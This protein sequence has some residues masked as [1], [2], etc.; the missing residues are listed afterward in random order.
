MVTLTV[1][2]PALASNGVPAV[3]QTPLGLPPGELRSTP[4][5]VTWK[6]A[7]TLR[8]PSSREPQSTSTVAPK[9][10]SVAPSGRVPKYASENGHPPV[11]TTFLTSGS[12]SGFP[13]SQ[14]R[15]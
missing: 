6:F 9:S 5:T 15:I 1:L 8:F 14:I 3:D 11:R 7:G 13:S 12:A 2:G 10:H 4:L